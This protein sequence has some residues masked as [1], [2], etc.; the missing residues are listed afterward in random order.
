MCTCRVAT[1]EL[2]YSLFGMATSGR[3]CWTSSCHPLCSTCAPC[4]PTWYDHYPSWL[5]LVALCLNKPLFCVVPFLHRFCP[6][7]PTCPLPLPTASSAR[8]SLWLQCGT[9][10]SPG[11]ASTRWVS[12][13]QLQASFATTR[14]ASSFI[15]QHQPKQQ[16]LKQLANELRV[17]IM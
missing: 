5:C 14:R 3:H 9:M 13:S 4:P 2:M 17:T 1:C 8:F 12:Q 11:Q 16:D 10:A 6:W 7:S 15:D